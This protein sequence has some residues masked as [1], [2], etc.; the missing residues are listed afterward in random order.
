MLS[1]H[2]ALHRVTSR[3]CRRFQSTMKPP[4]PFTIPSKGLVALAANDIPRKTLKKKVR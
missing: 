2:E 1:G 3:N 4:G